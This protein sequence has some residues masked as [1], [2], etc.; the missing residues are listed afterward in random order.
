MIHGRPKG[1]GGAVGAVA[2]NFGA[3][4][5]LFSVAVGCGSNKVEYK[6][7]YSF[8]TRFPHLHRDGFCCCFSIQ[9]SMLSDTRQHIPEL[10]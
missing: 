6:L 3:L 10:K 2:P 4:L 1:E 7:K 8:G 5:M 9:V